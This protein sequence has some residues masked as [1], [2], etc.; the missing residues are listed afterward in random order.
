MKEIQFSPTTQIHD[1][2]HKISKVPEWL[3]EG[4]KVKL[5]IRFSGRE[6]SHPE[7]G[8]ELFNKI[9]ALLPEAQVDKEPK[10]E[11][12]VMWTIL[13]RKSQKGVNKKIDKDSNKPAV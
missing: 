4:L 5:S 1:V 13:S 7:T 8:I 10:L 3:E 2:K 12:K 11:G 9:F 6:A